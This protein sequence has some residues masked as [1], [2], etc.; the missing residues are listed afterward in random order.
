[1]GRLD[2]AETEQSAADGRAHLGGGFDVAA[3]LSLDLAART[4]QQFQRGRRSTCASIWVCAFEQRQC[5]ALR[6]F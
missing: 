4:L 5:K 6:A 3:E 2:L 1:M